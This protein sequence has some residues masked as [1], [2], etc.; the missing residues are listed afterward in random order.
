VIIDPVFNSNIGISLMQPLLRG[1]RH[2]YAERQIV[3][4]RLNEGIS[5]IQF[6]ERVANVVEQVIGAYWRLA[7]TFEY[8]ETQRQ[9][10]DVAA[11]E[12]EQVA[13]RVKEGNDTASAL[14]AQRSE[15]ASHQQSLRESAVEAAQASNNLK[16]LLTTSVLDAL[17]PAGLIPT[18]KP[19]MKERTMS[20][21]DAINT[22]I[23]R[24]PELEQIRLQAKQSEAEVRFAQQEEKPA[25]NLRLDMASAGSAGTVYGLN[26]D[27]S[28]SQTPD[29][30]NAA[31]G[32]LGKSLG[33]VFRVDHPSVAGGLEV[34]LPLRNRVAKGQV[35]TAVLGERKAQSQ[36]RAMQEDVAVEVRNSWESFDAQ[37]VY[38]EAARVSRQA[39]EDR[40]SAEMAKPASDAQNL[41]ALRA[42]R[43]LESARMRELQ[44]LVDYQ[45]SQVS[46]EKATN[47][48][49]DDHQIVLARRKQAEQH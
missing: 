20:L 17:W 16:R 25:V 12:Y 31:Y 42:R 43:D 10:L 8:Y 27:G 2:T 33:Q 26:P 37:R 1:F 28:V 49:I 22:A 6:Q 44:A 39:A 9:G 14:A 5:D 47:T 19:D 38:V 11:A 40:L 41:E 48:L 34:T 7:I 45:T 4:S 36:M 13:K 21:E 29:L 35:E 46:L 30:T 23:D 3:V 18:D 15:V 24:R 32:G